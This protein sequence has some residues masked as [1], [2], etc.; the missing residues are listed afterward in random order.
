MEKL[1]C[2]CQHALIKNLKYYL[3]TIKVVIWNKATEEKMKKSHLIREMV[4]V[5]NQLDDLGLMNEANTLDKIASNLTKNIRTALDYSDA[6]TT[7]DD[8][9]EIRDLESEY[10]PNGTLNQNTHQFTSRE[11]EDEERYQKF[12]PKISKTISAVHQELSGLLNELRE[13][14]KGTDSPELIAYYTRTQMAIQKVL[15]TLQGY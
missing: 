6:E 8:I 1:P 15:Q 2:H 4:T 11:D 5:A 13:H 14:L 9:Q 12:H 7:D 10:T 3:P